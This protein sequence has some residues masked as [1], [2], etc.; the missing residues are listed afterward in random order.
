MRIHSDF[1]R[2]T[3]FLTTSGEKFNGAYVHMMEMKN[4]KNG[5]K[6]LL[7]AVATLVMVI[8]V[9]AV[10][11][12]A[13]VNG[14]TE[15]TQEVVDDGIQFEAGATYNVRGYVTLC[16]NT[17]L[18]G[19]TINVNVNGDS[20]YLIIPDGVKNGTIVNGTGFADGLA[21]IIKGGVIDTIVFDMK[22]WNVGSS[23]NTLDIIVRNCTFKSDVTNSAF[24]VASPKAN[25]T[26]ENNTYEMI[27][28]KD[29]GFSWDI[30]TIN[31]GQ[32]KLT[33]NE[34]SLQAVGIAVNSY[35][36]QI[37]TSMIDVKGNTEIAA[38]GVS[39]GTLNVDSDIEVGKLSAGSDEQIKNDTSGQTEKKITITEEYVVNGET[40]WES[41][42]GASMSLGSG[43]EQS[44]DNIVWETVELGSIL[45]S[46]VEGKYNQ[47]IEVVSD[48]V[49]TK[50]AVITVEGQFVVPEGVTV[51][52]QPGSKIIFN[53]GSSA[54]VNGD[55]VVEAG[56][57]DVANG[58]YV[59]TFN[60]E[61]MVV[62]GAMILE[63]VEA[64]NGDGKVVIE[65]TFEINEEATAVLDNMSVAEGGVLS[66]YGVATTTTTPTGTILNEGK[67]IISSEG[68]DNTGTKKVNVTIRMADTG[69]VIVDNVYGTVKVTDAGMKYTYNG[70]EKNVD[71][72]NE[73]TLSYVAG[74]TITESMKVMTCEGDCASH[75][76][77]EKY[78]Y[79]TMYI[80]GNIGVASNYSSEPL[81]SEEVPTVSMDGGNIAIVEDSAFM[82]LLKIADGS[83]S[84]S[85]NVTAAVTTTSNSNVTTYIPA[86]IN[87]GILDI[88][89]KVT[90]TGEPIDDK[91]TINAA[92]YM[93]K[94]ALPYLHVY[95]TL[96]QALANGATD[97][98]LTGKI[99]IDEDLVISVGTKVDASEAISVTIVNPATVTVKAEDRQSGKFITPNGSKSDNND[100]SQSVI[101]NG[102]LIV[103]DLTKSGVKD[104]AILS[105]TS[106]KVDPAMTYTNLQNALNSAQEGETV[107]VTRANAIDENS[108]L[109][110]KKDLTV[111]TGVTLLVPEKKFV[112]VENDVTVTVNGTLHVNGG[113]TMDAKNTS[114]PVEKAAGKTVIDGMMIINN[115][116]DYTGSIVGAYYYFKV[117][118]SVELVVT[119]LSTA[120]AVVNDI[121]GDEINLYGAQDVG[122]IV[123]DF[124][125]ENDET[126]TLIANSKLTGDITLD[127]VEFTVGAGKKPLLDVTLVMSQGSI[128]LDNVVVNSADICDV[129]SF[130][131]DAEVVT[132]YGKVDVKTYQNAKTQKYE[133]GSVSFVGN[134]TVDITTESTE[135]NNF[136]D[137]IV[138]VDATVTLIG[139]NIFDLKVDGAM[140]VSDDDAFL[141]IT[142]A[143]EPVLKA[144]N[145]TVSGTIA[146]APV[147]TDNREKAATLVV[148]AIFVGTTYE[149]VYGVK[150]DVLAASASVDGVILSSENGGTTGA[151][152]V[153]PGAVVS[154]TILMVG[155][156]AQAFTE[157][158]VGND[159]YMTVYG[160]F[161]IAK[162][163]YD[164]ENAIFKNW[165]YIDANGKV[166][167]V[168]SE[169]VV[170]EPSKVFA[171]INYNIYNVIVVADNGIGAVAIDGLQ[172]IRATSNTFV[173]AGNYGVDNPTELLVAG[174]HSLQYKLDAGY[175]DINVVIKVNGV[176][177]SGL[178]FTLSGVPEDGEDMDVYIN[179]EGTEKV[180]VTPVGPSGSAGNDGGMTLTEI[181]LIVL[182]VL[183][184][185]MAIIVAMRLMRS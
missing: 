96:D 9:L 22:K 151:A 152:F 7:A 23:Q 114:G 47:I 139:A 177:V 46:T 178:D 170:G 156:K 37:N 15:L 172:L 90:T 21:V 30:G 124:T 42:N 3:R 88:T 17:D 18:N 50:D 113:Y 72:E 6:K 106:K 155:D 92:Y 116:Y 140:I 143:P 183:I 11:P 82:V 108:A 134:V 56:V 85:A 57:G 33:I 165:Q 63:G 100:G 43:G 109:K 55:I 146:S 97:I 89:G 160:N 101:V 145:V 115:G 19:A 136:V 164:A 185:I 119:P 4:K 86:I 31:P 84:I 10:A 87:G 1:I 77:G 66:I 118:R 29:V 121:D 27:E 117:D 148:D 163:D 38:L 49:V 112:N 149:Q 171:F 128:I 32:S 181:L 133:N 182:V 67:V 144:A 25:V 125:P 103:E 94:D 81:S 93:V 54:Q 48:L 127:G 161:K 59:F 41:I 174:T 68:N 64:Y 184:L 2:S 158:Y 173:L 175:N 129:I 180:D 126:M 52:F 78:G 16:E 39:S 131:E 147:D 76:E 70:T 65:G 179:I 71:Y 167:D 20:A 34:A 111:P 60:G 135:T 142:D 166:E 157:Y 83:V 159:L 130:K 26:F 51:T 104:N 13:N 98:K 162:L 73:I 58:N 5:Q 137:V 53:V 61:E 154:N 28:G 132:S 110:I 107:E 24:Y 35:K 95:T 45:T 91:G 120:A 138:P 123:F 74:V 12:M 79:N 122:D 14:Q 99:V 75:S 105:D 80:V 153:A 150:S 102:T 168:G 176:A 40:K 44:F 36:E 169:V 141:G 8:C 62:A 69:T